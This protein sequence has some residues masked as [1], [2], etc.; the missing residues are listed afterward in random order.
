M[1]LKPGPVNKLT[2]RL[3]GNAFA[4]LRWCG[5][6]RRQCEFRRG[7]RRIVFVV[8]CQLAGDGVDL[9]GGGEWFVVVVEIA[10]SSVP[11]IPTIDG[12][13]LVSDRAL[14]G[15]ST[16]IFIH[17]VRID[18]R[19]ATNDTCALGVKRECSLCIMISTS[20]ILFSIRI[21]QLRFQLMQ[22][23]TTSKMDND[24]RH[25]DRGDFTLRHLLKD[26]AAMQP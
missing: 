25:T 3:D 2:A 23:Q 12:V 20:A 7:N 17:A 4:R 6:W 5:S 15:F 13:V 26:Q 24:L 9:K 11:A 16:G 14:D 19:D 22:F 8:L 21:T 1:L 18:R 10:S